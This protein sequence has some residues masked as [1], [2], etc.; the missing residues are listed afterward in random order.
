MKMKKFI[1]KNSKKLLMIGFILFV[2][3]QIGLM[4]YIGS[5][6]IYFL[7]SGIMAFVLVG[8]LGLNEINIAYE[9]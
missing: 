2:F 9:K 7:T 8:W 4:F 1:I 5:D 6:D 3:S